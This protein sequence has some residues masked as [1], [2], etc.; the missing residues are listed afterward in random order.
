MSCCCYCQLCLVASMLSFWVVG[1]AY[2]WSGC[3]QT[4]FNVGR[5]IK[6]YILGSGKVHCEILAVHHQCIFVKYLL[7]VLTLKLM[8]MFPS[9]HTLMQCRFSYS[10]LL[11]MDKIAFFHFAPASRQLLAYFSQGLF[12]TCEWI[13]VVVPAYHQCMKSQSVS[14]LTEVFSNWSSN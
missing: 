5:C 8:K 7:R 4:L 1:A 3:V 2:C 9:L 12:L 11:S 6:V 13:R 10:V 14:H